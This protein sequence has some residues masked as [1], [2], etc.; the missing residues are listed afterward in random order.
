MTGRLAPWGLAAAGLVLLAAGIGLDPS[1]FQG[2]LLPI[3]LSFAVVGALIASRRPENPIGWLFLAF[4]VI[5]A[6]DFA[7]YSY[8]Y[9]ALVSHP[10]ALPAGDVAAAVAGHVWHPGF[11]LLVFS[12]LVFPRGRLLSPRWRWAA[13]AT[14]VIY[15]GLAVSGIFEGGF[16]EGESDLPAK[17]L[18]HGPVEEVARAVFGTL[19]YVNLGLLV[20][21]GTSLILR[22]R[23]SRGEERQQIKWFAYTVAFVMFAFPVTLFALGDAYGVF[24]FPLIPVSAAA[25]ILK[26][27]LYDID[28]VVNRTL[29]YG[30]LTA[31]LAGAYLA[32]VLVLQ[33]LLSPSSDVAIAASTLAAAALFRPARSRIQS[34]VD[35]RFYRRRYDAHRALDSFAARLRNEVSLEAMDAELRAVV[36]DTV[37][38]A[39]VSLWLKAAADRDGRAGTPGGSVSL[40]MSNLNAKN[41]K[42]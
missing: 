24:V 23:R 22:L 8:A 4:G 17:P 7:A 14:V 29:V 36:R 28:V 38:P 27:R 25:A 31:T 16:L 34:L 18:F 10:G 39:H 26:Y 40:P 12:F 9:R 37:Q 15:A 30:A 11:G 20:V 33:L 19:L 2:W 42:Q 13:G 21:A 1:L 35:R 5:A 3:A 41:H 32:S 6:V